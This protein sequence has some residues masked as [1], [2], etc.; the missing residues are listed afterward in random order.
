MCAHVY[1]FLCAGKA[2]STHRIEV[3]EEANAGWVRRLQG[4]LEEGLHVQWGRDDR[5][6]PEE[7]WDRP[8]SVYASCG[9][10]TNREIRDI[11]E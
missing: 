8:R 2:A 6:A 11:V 5:W 9:R 3:V 10:C 7:G 4:E 1:T